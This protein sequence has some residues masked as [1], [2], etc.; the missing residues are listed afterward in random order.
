VVEHRACSEVFPASGRDV[1]HISLYGGR[2]V[3]TSSLARK[4]AAF[5]HQRNAFPGGVVGRNFADIIASIDTTDTAVAK[6]SLHDILLALVNSVKPFKKPMLLLLD[7]VDT[8]SEKDP[9]PCD[10][11]AKLHSA[12]DYNTPRGLTCDGCVQFGRVRDV[13]GGQTRGGGTKLLQR[14]YKDQGGEMRSPPRLGV[15]ADIITEPRCAV[16]NQ[17]MC[18]T[19]GRANTVSVDNLDV[20]D[21]TKPPNHDPDRVHLICAAH[22]FALRGVGDNVLDVFASLFAAAGRA[23]ALE[24]GH[25]KRKAE[26]RL[27]EREMLS[28]VGCAKVRTLVQGCRDSDHAHK[29]QVPPREHLITTVEVQE[30][31]R[32]QGFRCAYSDLPLRFSTGDA[33]TVSVE[34]RV[35]GS[36]PHTKANCLLVVRPL[37]TPTANSKQLFIGYMLSQTRVKVPAAA[38]DHLQAAWDR[39]DR[40]EAA[41]AARAD[42]ED[43]GEEGEGEGED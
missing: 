35:H 10:R 39:L 16:C 6:K 1:R 22:N 36:S 15:V 20:S 9:R 32:Q 23:W 43:E 30:L 17:E 24:A 27:A 42:D 5:L 3:G 14:L 33:C 21:G 4:V 29:R 34:R 18:A 2:G 41:R 13:C 26:E 28:R 25:P 11:C 31:A 40:E 7:D 12:D 38:R 8:S 19:S 37:N